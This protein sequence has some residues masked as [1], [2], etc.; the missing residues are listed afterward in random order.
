MVITAQTL[1][2]A[3]AANAKEFAILLALGIPRWRISMMVLTQSFWVG[4]IGIVLSYPMCLGL[5]YAR[6]PA[7]RRRGPALGGAGRHRGRD[8]RHGALRRHASRL[9]SVPADR[10]DVAA[11]LMRATWSDSHAGI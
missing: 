8:H 7:W 4:V 3:T 6:A 9:R 5:R 2:S 1:Y 11:S 10:A